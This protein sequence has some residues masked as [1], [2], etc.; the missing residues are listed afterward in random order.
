MSNKPIKMYLETRQPKPRYTKRQRKPSKRT[1]PV[2]KAAQI[3]GNSRQQKQAQA[4]SRDRTPLSKNNLLLPVDAD[5]RD[6]LLAYFDPFR[7]GPISLPYPPM[8][9]HQNILSIAN[10]SSVTNA[11]GIAWITIKPCLAMINDIHFGSVSGS[12]SGDTIN[13][14]ASGSTDIYSS[15]PYGSTDFAYGDTDDYTGRVVAQGIRVRYTGTTLNAAGD[16]YT[17]QLQSRTNEA[18]VNTFNV[19]SIKAQPAWKEAEFVRNRWHTLARQIQDPSDFMYL[20]YNSGNFCYAN[21]PS[22]PSLDMAN[23]MCIY[24]Q[25]T[26][27]VPFEYEIF[28]HFEIC[29]PDL[30]TRRTIRSNHRAVEEAQN[31]A[32]LLRFNN[33]T[34]ADAGVGVGTKEGTGTGLG[35]VIKDIGHDIVVGGAKSLL[36]SIFG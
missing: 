33:T 34:T 30:P 7:K 1:M 23:N 9:S 36:E 13:F 6:F 19:A 32:S 26:P 14:G 3:L 17:L 27:S 20:T 31:N 5:T 8:V 2:D 15:S 4:K 18:S 12:T 35:R 16:C 21:N 11:D 22:I 25:A 28:T 10:G 29:G 24:I